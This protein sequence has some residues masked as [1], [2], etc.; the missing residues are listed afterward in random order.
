[1]AL[2]A[3]DVAALLDAAGLFAEV[4]LPDNSLARTKRL[5]EAF[6]A[7]PP[8]SVRALLVAEQ[9]TEGAYA[10]V[11]AKGDPDK[12]LLFAHAERN[13][14]EFEL[15]EH[16][17]PISMGQARI[18]IL[19]NTQQDSQAASE[20]KR[21][22]KLCS[23]IFGA[24]DFAAG[25]GVS[26]FVVAAEETLP[27]D[28]D[29][30]PI[31][32]VPSGDFI[33]ARRFDEDAVRELIATGEPGE[34]KI[35]ERTILLVGDSTGNG[36]SASE[37]S[38]MIGAAVN[39]HLYS[40]GSKGSAFD[41]M[42]APL[43]RMKRSPMHEA[44]LNANTSDRFTNPAWRLLR[45]VHTIGCSIYESAWRRDDAIFL[46]GVDAAVLV[47]DTLEGGIQKVFWANAGA[48]LWEVR[49]DAGG[50]WR[51]SPLVNPR[52]PGAKTSPRK[53]LITPDAGGA[54]QA[55]VTYGTLTDPAPV[56]VVA[57]DGLRD[58]ARGAGTPLETLENEAIAAVMATDAKTENLAKVFL[59]TWLT[60]AKAK[61]VLPEDIA[62][63]IMRL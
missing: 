27:E 46:P 52:P 38:A 21:V 23:N 45:W 10:T 25:P 1:M 55:D 3:D 40:G 48:F 57:T 15:R 14:S 42:W 12:Y 33:L 18:V 35:I 31:S 60:V 13:V 4:E 41:A 17:V 63:G 49:P 37:L 30:R 56:Y 11:R 22:E 20:R 16:A 26:G 19:R 34:D 2:S 28:T 8:Q 53:S 36:R 61:P 24:A 47:R 7:L 44:W 9:P 51:M 6:P 32:N 29:A 54:V 62:V 43:S 39:Q 5:Q 59:T 50:A 58:T